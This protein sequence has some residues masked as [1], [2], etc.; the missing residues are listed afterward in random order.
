MFTPNLEKSPLSNAG[1][2][3]VVKPGKLTFGLM[4]LIEAYKGDTPSMQNQVELAQY[5]EQNGFTSLA[6]RDVPLRDPS[7]GDSGQVFDPWVYLGYITAYTQ[8]ITLITASLVVPLRHP[9]HTA[10]A[11]ASVDHLSNGRLLLGLSTGDRPVEYPAFNVDHAERGKI[12]R[13]QFELIQKY[14]TTSFETIQSPYG[15]LKKADV[16]PKPV[17]SRIP[18]LVVGH[19]QNS[20]EWIAKNADG[21][22]TY[23][24]DPYRQQ[25]VIQEWKQALNQ[26]AAGQFKPFIQGLSLDLTKNP[27]AHPYPIHGGYMVG[28]NYLITVLKDLQEIGVNHIIF[29]LKYSNRPADEVLQELAEFILPQFN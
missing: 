25:L 22:M 28:R 12:F 10:K 9:I 2:T 5:A 13:E 8:R 27:N 26:Q 3:N 23:G 4:F 6:F 19:S 15:L 29:G 17:A 24:R 1:F 18:M 21:W 14:W 16:I 7:F 20:L 11:A